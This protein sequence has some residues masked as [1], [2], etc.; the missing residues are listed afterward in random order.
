MFTSGSKT[1]VNIRNFNVKT[2]EPLELGI[3][4]VRQLLSE[5]FWDHSFGLKHVNSF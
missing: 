4:R 2:A 3:S 1:H 5:G